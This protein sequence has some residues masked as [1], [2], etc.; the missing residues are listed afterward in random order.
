VERHCL[1][2]SKNIGG[3]KDSKEKGKS[4]QGR[5]IRKKE[6]IWPV[7]N[8]EKE[9]WKNR[10]KSSEKIEEGLVKKNR[11]EKVGM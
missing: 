7:E 10:K 6:V 8:L 3:A 9:S 5:P 11:G 1:Q 2:T 4:Q